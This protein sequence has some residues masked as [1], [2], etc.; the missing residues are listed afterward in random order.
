MIPDPLH[1]AIVHFPIALALIV[2]VV[3]AAAVWAI[4]THR[5]RPAA[6]RGVVLL[7]AALVGSAWLALATGEREEERVERVVAERPIEHH[8]Q[9]A[10]RFVWL[11]SLTLAVAGFGLLA[12]APGGAARGLTLTTSLA[13]VAAVA[14]A[15]HTGGS[16]T[17]RHGAAAAYTSAGRAAAPGILA[18]HEHDD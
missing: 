3:A 18:R 15:G 12:G 2:P 17:Y 11:A 1:H 6:W 10:E 9:A 7:Q 13:V 5:L 4:R 14:L 16:L 8:E